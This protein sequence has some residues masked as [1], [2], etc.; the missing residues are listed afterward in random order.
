M[1]L[2]AA[3]RETVIS[4]SDVDNVAVIYSASPVFIRKM[5]R[6][7]LENPN[8][9]QELIDRRQY[10]DEEK[11]IIQSKTYTMPKHLISI[12]TKSRTYTDEQREA[13][14]ERM[15]NIRK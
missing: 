2:T 13:M 5:D 15:R 8:E 7:L 10:M 4:F 12:R 9:F 1:A 6:L 3:E 11:N 14:A